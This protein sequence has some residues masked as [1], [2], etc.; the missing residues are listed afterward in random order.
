[1]SSFG[2]PRPSR[3]RYR[4]ARRSRKR[5]RPVVGETSAGGLV[6]KVEN[7]VGY[8]ALIARRNRNSEIEW[9]LPKGHVEQGEKLAETARREIFEETGIEGE[10]LAPLATIDYW[11]SGSGRYVH[12]VVHHYLLQA[13][14]GTIG[15]D[16]DPDQEAEKAEWIPLDN[17]DDLLVYPNER[18]VVAK[19]RALLLDS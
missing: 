12:K 15:V 17:V 3:R 8:V 5:R 13:T 18:H 9:C 2:S 19:A 6:I 14:G 11:F 1:M 7:G 4:S 16:N 10:V